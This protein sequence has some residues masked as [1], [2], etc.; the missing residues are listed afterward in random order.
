MYIYPF[1]VVKLGHYIVIAIFPFVTATKSKK[2]QG[3]L[4]LTPECIET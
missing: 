1:F 4:G 3:L 2:E